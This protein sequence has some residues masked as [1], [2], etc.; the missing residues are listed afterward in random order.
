M[1]HA[2]ALSNSEVQASASQD[3]LKNVVFTVY[4]LEDGGG[5]RANGIWD[6]NAL[7]VSRSTPAAVARSLP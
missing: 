4:E 3:P 2:G 5:Y 1:E 6:G 7:K